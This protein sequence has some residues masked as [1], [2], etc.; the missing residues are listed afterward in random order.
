MSANFQ[1]DEEAA[2]ALLE[3]RFP[4]HKAAAMKGQ[5][6]ALIVLM[7]TV[8]AD[9]E[10]SSSGKSAMH[11]AAEEGNEGALI[12]LVQAGAAVDKQD[13]N[14]DAPIHKAAMGGHDKVVSLLLE[15]GADKDMK[16]YN[17]ANLSASCF[18]GE[19]GGRQNI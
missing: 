8:E 4:L 1:R 7:E 17:G 11:I 12:V 10:D 9:Q 6:G 2:R 3:E 5:E 16:G 14:G 15:A 18:A 13:G 19:F